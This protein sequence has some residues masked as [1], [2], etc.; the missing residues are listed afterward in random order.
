MPDP[1][2]AGASTDWDTQALSTTW[3]SLAN[4]SL[5]LAAALLWVWPWLATLPLLLGF[6]GHTRSRALLR[7]ATAQ[8]S[9]R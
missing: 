5:C 4:A 8:R 1:F 2:T 3:C 9:R 7:P 6:W